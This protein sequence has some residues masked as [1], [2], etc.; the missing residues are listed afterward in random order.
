MRSLRDGA[1]AALLPALVLSA[2][3]ACAASP[4]VV[5]ARGPAASPRVVIARDQALGWIG[6]APRPTRDPRDWIPAGP[7]AVL[8]PMPAGLTEGLADGLTA[9]PAA[10]LSGAAAAPSGPA[11][12]PSGPA[13]P[14]AEP[15]GP[16]A[17]LAAGTTLRAIDARGGI[18][19][20][21][22]AGPTRVRYGCDDQQLDMIA[23]TGG[24]SAPGPVWLLPPG[25]PASW[26]PRALAIERAG[27]ATEARRRDTVGPLTLVLVRSGAARATLAIARG[28]RVLHTAAIVR[29]EM[30]G[31]DPA[32]LDLRYPGVAIPEPVAAWSFADGGP[33][34]LVL[35][36]PSY[37]GVH[38]TPILVE[39]DRA[40]E[41]PMLAAYLYRC[42]F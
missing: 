12:A 5:A 26:R 22:S 7:Q 42:A 18:A 16:A 21:T 32:P 28:G 29:D 40:R 25:A 14:A 8:V 23:F 9:G 1:C 15:S 20:V 27:E 37:E 6:L 34:L 33:V 11:A 10:A 31:A 2:L 38:L 36:V 19:Q 13:G 4:R 3:A 39:D 17:G 24:A 30:A 35:E 41:L